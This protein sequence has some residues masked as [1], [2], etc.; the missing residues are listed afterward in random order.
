MHYFPDKDGNIVVTKLNE[1]MCQEIAQAGGGMY[2][3]ADNAASAVRSLSSE[4]NK[5]NKTDIEEMIYSEYNEQYAVIGWI[6]FVLLLLEVIL[7][8]R[9]N[10]LFK[11]IKLF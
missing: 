2:V 8:E 11:N 7:S 6:V 10:P 9:K 1:T 5:M 4:L 3:R